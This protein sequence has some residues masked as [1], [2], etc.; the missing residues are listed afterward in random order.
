MS[1]VCIGN[2][3]E[4]L[5]MF[6][7]M[8]DAMKRMNFS[9]W[10]IWKIC[11]SDEWCVH[12]KQEWK[13][14]HVLFRAWCYV[15]D[16]ERS[17]AFSIIDWGAED[18]SFVGICD[19]GTSW[20]PPSKPSSLSSNTAT[21]SGTN[22]NTLLHKLIIHSACH[23]TLSSWNSHWGKDIHLTCLLLVVKAH[24]SYELRKNLTSM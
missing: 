2:M 22:T 1:D 24:A 21:A 4:N 14:W 6:C 13:L 16:A 15:K 12:W 23:R 5:D 8:L 3:N 19:H 17:Y 20:G 18:K 9:V 10:E 7:F 11:S